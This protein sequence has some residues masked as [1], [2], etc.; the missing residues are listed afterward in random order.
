MVYPMVLTSL[1]NPEIVLPPKTF[2]EQQDLPEIPLGHMPQPQ[3]YMFDG[4][5]GLVDLSWEPWVPLMQQD[6]IDK[7]LLYN[8]YLYQEADDYDDEEEEM[9]I[10]DRMPGNARDAC[11]AGPTGT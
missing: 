3:D 8:Q 7:N 11:V 9:E 4:I 6:D 5:Q 10:D 1:L 2:W